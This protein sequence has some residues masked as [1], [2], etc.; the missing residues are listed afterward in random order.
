MP[1]FA[2]KK[3]RLWHKVDW[4]PGYLIYKHPK[5]NTSAQKFI[6]GVI[7]QLNKAHSTNEKLDFPIIETMRFTLFKEEH[8]V[9]LLR[10]S[11]NMKEFDK[12]TGTFP[13]KTQAKLACDLN[14]K[15]IIGNNRIDKTL[16]EIRNSSLYQE[17]YKKLL[18]KYS[19]ESLSLKK[20]APATFS[21]RSGL[22]PFRY[23][24]NTMNYMENVEKILADS[25]SFAQA[26]TVRDVTCGS[27]VLTFYL[28]SKYPNKKYIASD[29]NGELINA[30]NYLKQTDMAEIERGYTNY[31]K[32]VFDSPPQEQEKKYQELLQKFNEK[33]PK[34]YCL[35]IFLQNNAYT[36]VIFKSDGNISANFK[37]NP[38]R[39]TKPSYRIEN[40]KKCKDIMA[41]TEIEFKQLDMHIAVAEARKGEFYFMTPPHE[42]DREGLY[43]EYLNKNELVN[44]LRLMNKNDIPYLITYGDNTTQAASDLRKDV[45]TVRFSYVVLG[46]IEK[47]PKKLSIY[48][49]PNVITDSEKLTSLVAHFAN[50]ASKTWKSAEKNLDVLKNQEKNPEIDTNI[51]NEESAQQLANEILIDGGFDPCPTF[52]ITSIQ[53]SKTEKQME[54]SPH[55]G[56]STIST[57]IPIDALDSDNGS[58]KRNEP[59]NLSLFQGVFS[60]TFFG[61][62]VG[63][64]KKQR[65]IRLKKE[66]LR[67]VYPLFNLAYRWLTL[68][69]MIPQQKKI[70][71]NTG[72]RDISGLK[73]LDI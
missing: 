6:L 3:S 2:Q 27:C 53:A 21:T 17:E 64:A 23:F 9:E 47:K 8:A 19:M 71:L 51:H 57:F 16:T 55:S 10:L 58:E 42:F 4:I 39:Q 46:G 18:T 56:H 11:P 29:I 66:N 72:K 15:K 32:T 61:K 35:L 54:D 60:G 5:K 1:S 49:S 14:S 68:K 28:A 43:I 31:H 63:K 73:F 44:S 67:R 22:Q 52:G 7:S 40:I 70:L 69:M 26:D 24:G 59:A 36:N 20:K 37:R 50:L 45:A 41:K 62:L 13:E 12:A 34:D 33:S 30:L 65:P 25:T 48:I 38:G